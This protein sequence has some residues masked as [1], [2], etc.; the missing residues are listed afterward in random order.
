V[1]IELVGEQFVIVVHLTEGEYW[2]IISA[3]LQEQPTWRLED[4]IAL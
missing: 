3:V 1:S 4:D 2:L